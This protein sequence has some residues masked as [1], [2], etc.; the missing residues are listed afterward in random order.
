EAERGTPLAAA[1]R[2]LAAPGGDVERY[3]DAVVLGPLPSALRECALDS[4]PLETLD[5]VTCDRVRGAGDAAALFAALDERGLVRHRGGAPRLLAPLRARLRAALAG[6]P[7]RRD[8]IA[9]SLAALRALDYDQGRA[10]PA[11]AS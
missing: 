1:L 6:Q 10:E 3:L 8:R 7:R 9:W 11:V 2:L 4:A 5:P